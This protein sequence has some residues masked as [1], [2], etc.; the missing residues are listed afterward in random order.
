M[1]YQF[2]ET[3]WNSLKNRP[4]GT[5]TKR[6]LELLFIQSAIDSGLIEATPFHIATDLN[7]TVSR[8]NN[9]LNDIALR[10]P[11]LSDSQ[12]VHDLLHQLRKCEV[13]P[14]DRHLSIPLGDAALRI[15][16]E[17]KLSLHQLHH[18]ES[19]RQDLIKITPIGLLKILDDSKGV[20]KP[21]EALNF[22]PTD[23]YECDW[24]IHAKSHWKQDTQW[25]DIFTMID[26]T[27]KTMAFFNDLTRL[28][29]TF[30]S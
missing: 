16:L 10:K 1:F 27:A 7:L 11:Q 15:W 28:M 23:I 9:Y 12:G 2:G 6:E 30:F 20:R 4:F 19:L 5:L 14:D 21:A 3:I 25:K 29:P 8:A 18:G 13:L 17:R 24:V 26:S 22:L